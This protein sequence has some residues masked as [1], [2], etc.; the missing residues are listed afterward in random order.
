MFRR[1]ITR[2]RYLLRNIARATIHLNDVW[3]LAIRILATD[4]ACVWGGGGEGV[5]SVC[6]MCAT[7]VPRKHH[8]KPTNPPAVKLIFNPIWIIILHATRNTKWH[9]VAHKPRRNWNINL[10]SCDFLI[11]AA[12]ASNKIYIQTAPKNQTEPNQK[13]RQQQQQQ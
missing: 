11:N 4:P 9:T 6:R 13:K 10:T 2:E 1:A 7:S 5:L 3:V 12:E 8:P